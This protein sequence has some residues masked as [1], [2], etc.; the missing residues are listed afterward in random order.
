MQ[1]K[2][3]LLLLTWVPQAFLKLRLTYFRWVNP[4]SAGTLSQEAA[5]R[6]GEEELRGGLSGL[7]ILPSILVILFSRAILLCSTCKLRKSYRHWGVIR[8]VFISQSKTVKASPWMSQVTDSTDIRFPF[9]R[10]DNWARQHMKTS[11]RLIICFCWDFLIFMLRFTNFSLVE[12]SKLQC[13][14]S[15]KNPLKRLKR[16]FLSLV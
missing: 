3:A 10:L 12:C 13:T 5:N 6:Q 4:T 15:D 2:V 14:G 1:K 9:H 7:L 11:E 16:V 8:T